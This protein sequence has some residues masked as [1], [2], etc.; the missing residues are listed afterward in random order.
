[1]IDAAA[2]FMEA[3]LGRRL[4]ASAHAVQREVA[5]D[6]RI[7]PSR[8]DP[9]VTTADPRDAVLVRGMVDLVLALPDQIEI[10][11]YKTDAVTGEQMAARAEAYRPQLEIY[12]HALRAAHRTKVARCWLVFLHPRQIVEIT[13]AHT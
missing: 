5:F 8:Y 11:D 1:M 4:R 2:W 13:S 3:D 9:R 12:A 7:E 10:V 6:A